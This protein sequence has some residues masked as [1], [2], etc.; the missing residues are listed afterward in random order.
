MEFPLKLVG[1]ET[2]TLIA[3]TPG[4]FSS[5]NLLVDGIPAKPNGKG[6]FV[7]QRSDG[8]DVTV[9]IKTSWPDPVPVIF[10]NEEKI[11]LESPFKWY[12]TLL[13]LSP[14]LLVAIGGLIGAVIGAIAT[15][16]NGRISRTHWPPALRYLAIGGMG[17]M[18]YL[19]YL[20][21]GVLYV[22]MR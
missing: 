3:K 13:I 14:F 20:I 9:R 12:Q 15:D 5:V 2:Q 21:A 7:I 6:G 18:A 22:V 4:I 11:L 17:I 19:T 10:V 8:A 16:I 1:F